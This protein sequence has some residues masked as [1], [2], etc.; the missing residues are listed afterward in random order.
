[1]NKNFLLALAAWGVV[2]CGG[3]NETVVNASIAVPFDLLTIESYEV[4]LTLLDSS[5]TSTLRGPVPLTQDEQNLLWVGEVLDVDEQ[6]FLAVVDILGPLADGSDV[7]LAH[8]SRAIT[9]P[10][11]AP[12]VTITFK[13]SDFDTDLDDDGDTLTNATEYANGLNPKLVDSDGDGV[14]DPDE[15]GGVS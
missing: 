15:L 9:V 2:A 6:D 5:G 7:V 1:M 3:P 12:F 13:P 8:A 11:G 10:K 14:S 4:E